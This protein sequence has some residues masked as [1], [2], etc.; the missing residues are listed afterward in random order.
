MY[1]WKKLTLNV[2]VAYAISWAYFFLTLT[3]S[4]TMFGKVNGTLI[5]YMLSWGL[6][7]IVLIILTKLSFQSASDKK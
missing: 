2:I 3:L 1:D 6:M 7:I 5:N 4:H